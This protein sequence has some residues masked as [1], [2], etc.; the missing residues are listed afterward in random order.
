MDKNTERQREFEMSMGKNE[1]QRL[2]E[3]EID[4]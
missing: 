2:I 4:T 3:T 1:T